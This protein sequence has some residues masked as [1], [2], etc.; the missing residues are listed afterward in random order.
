MGGI[1][2]RPVRSEEFSIVTKRERWDAF[3]DDPTEES[4]LDF[5]ATWWSYRYFGARR[6][7]VRKRVVDDGYTPTEIRDELESRASEG[8]A[9]IEAD[10]PGIGVATLSEVL[11][12]IDPSRYATLN[13][14]SRSAVQ[15]LGYLDPGNDPG[16][17]AYRRFTENVKEIVPKYDLRNAVQARVEGPV[18]ENAEATDVAQV[19]FLMHEREKHDFALED[20]RQ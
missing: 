3:R 1:W 15:A 6:Y 16:A 8:S 4:L 11:E 13:S 10:I 17:T 18:P 14:M 5:G 7:F 12:V 2:D 9:A 19:A 20:L